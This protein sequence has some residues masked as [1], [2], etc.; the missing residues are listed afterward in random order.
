MIKLAHNKCPCETWAGLEI[1]P[2]CAN[3]EA[4]RKQL[5]TLKSEV[6][7]SNRSTFLA[8][9][10]RVDEVLPTV[11]AWLATATELWEEM[12]LRKHDFEKEA[13]KAKSKE[14]Y[15]RAQRAAKFLQG[16]VPG[17]A[18]KVL[19]SMQD[20]SEDT[21]CCCSDSGV[22]HDVDDIKMDVL[23]YY[24]KPSPFWGVVHDHLAKLS[25]DFPKLSPL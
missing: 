12:K 9:Q 14:R 8:L 18:A 3:V 17:S 19:G 16:G 6:A 20:V 7:R 13:T 24:T 11:D 25:G 23:S 2:L 1:E 15:Q 4:S 10:H 21:P 22:V 5:D